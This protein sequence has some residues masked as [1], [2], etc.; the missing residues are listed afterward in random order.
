MRIMNFI[1]LCAAWSVMSFLK[2]EI[3]K[4][5]MIHRHCTSVHSSMVYMVLCK[6]QLPT[7]LP[8]VSMYGVYVCMY[9]HSKCILLTCVVAASLVF[10]VLVEQPTYSVQYRLSIVVYFQQKKISSYHLTS[11]PLA[12][13]SIRAQFYRVTP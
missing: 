7:F 12:P 10:T 11:Y 1:G 4:M 6:H 2:P 5:D 9:V 3:I 13:F 8:F